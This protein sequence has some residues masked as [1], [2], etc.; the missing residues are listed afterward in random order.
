MEINIDAYGL[1]DIG[2]RREKNEDQFF[3]AEFNGSMKVHHTSVPIENCSTIFGRSQGHLL[4][5]ADGLGGHVAGDRASSLAISAVSAYALNSLQWLVQSSND[6]DVSTQLQS[7]AAECQQRL[8]DSAREHPKECGMA[9]TLTVAIILWPRLYVMHIGDSRC[10]LVRD[11]KPK[12]LTRDH[13]IGQLYSES[14]SDIGLGKGSNHALWNVVSSEGNAA[15]IADVIEIELNVADQVLLC[16]DGLYNH[17]DDATI[18]DVLSTAANPTDACEQ[19]VALANDDGGKDN[20]TV[21]LS[22]FTAVESPQG[23]A[24]MVETRIPLERVIEHSEPQ[25]SPHD[26]DEFVLAA[27]DM[28]S[29]PAS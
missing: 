18:G 17:V 10:Y 5:V 16:T 1:T 24:V 15:P 6:A 8:C 28:K 26:T 11:G 9:T 25:P 7:I 27:P 20:I 2:K 29:K 12:Q 4:L 3:I 21:V 19:L 13:T 14:G 23:D 22:R